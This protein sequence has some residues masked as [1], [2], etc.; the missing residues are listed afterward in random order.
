VTLFICVFCTLYTQI[1]RSINMQL[2][3]L[4]SHDTCYDA[5]GLPLQC[6][7][8][9]EMDVIYDCTGEPLPLT[10]VRSAN[11]LVTFICVL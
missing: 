8:D 11:A 6:G 3:T 1:S 10:L 9:C 7:G 5:D 2:Y 4:S